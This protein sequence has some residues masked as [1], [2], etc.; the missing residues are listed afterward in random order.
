MDRKGKKWEK[1][2]NIMFLG[3]YLHTIDERSRVSVPKKFRE[4]L[5]GPVVVTRGLDGCLF[6]YSRENWKKVEEKILMTPLTR[7][8]AR[9]FARLMFSGAMELELDRLGR[10]LLPKYLTDYAGVNSEV[11]ILGVGER[12]EIWDKEIWESYSNDLALK[13]DEIAERLSELGI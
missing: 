6:L 10:I 4:K 11:A 12:I 2:G 7:S 3:T 9:S 8:D 5:G 1:V 13:R